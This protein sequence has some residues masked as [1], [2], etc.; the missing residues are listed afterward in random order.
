MDYKKMWLAL[1]KAV[2]EDYEMYAGGKIP[3]GSYSE[4]QLDEADYIL[5]E[6]KFLEAQ[7]MLKEAE[8]TESEV[9]NEHSENS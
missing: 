6:I 7:E 8:E 9:K 3:L 4:G 1:K 5:G 2:K